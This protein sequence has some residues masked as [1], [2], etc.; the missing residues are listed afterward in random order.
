MTASI[1]LHVDAPLETD[2]EVTGAPAQAHYVGTVMRQAAGAEVLLFNGA[3]GEWRA[4]VTLVRRDRLTLRVTARTRPQT[5]GPDLWLAFA[6]L[7]RD[8]TDLV[9]RAATELG[10]RRLVPVLTA[11]TQ[12]ARVNTE[13]LAAIATEAAEQCERL[14]VPSVAAPVPLAA[15]LSG[16]DAVRA[17][18]VALERSGAGPPGAGTGAGPRALLVGP[19]GGIA[20]E[21]A[22]LLRRLP[23]VRPFGLGPR[24]LRAET[25]A[26]AGLAL[27]AL[28]GQENGA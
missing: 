12:A 11:R 8:A 5:A 1:R 28:H 27:L 26:I 16:W 23:F 9:A 17:L 19:E 3:D 14:D 2:A 10:V 4:T 6:V 18:H 21:E 13:R 25:A 15:L 22:A 24:I 20:P 7:K